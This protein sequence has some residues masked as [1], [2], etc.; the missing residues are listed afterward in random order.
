MSQNI[1][2]YVDLQAQAILKKV[3]RGL[4]GRAIAH[5]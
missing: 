1:D 5:S 2:Q 3:C 4:P